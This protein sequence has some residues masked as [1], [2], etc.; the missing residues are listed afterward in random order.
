MEP[1][2]VDT[3]KALNE[4]LNK[5][6]HTASL[7]VRFKEAR[8]NLG[9]S[10]VEVAAHL[11]LAEHV[12]EDIEKDDYSQV[13]SDVYAKGYLRTYAKFVGLPESEILEQYSASGLGKSIVSKQPQLIEKKPPMISRKHQRWAT[14]ALSGILFI[15]F[16]YWWTSG[17]SDNEDTSLLV[18]DA[19]NNVKNEKPTKP[20]KALKKV[21]NTTE[22]Q[23]ITLAKKDNAEKENEMSMSETEETKSANYIE[24]SKTLIVSPEDVLSG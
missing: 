24:P 15:G 20:N 5:V 8:N 3:T 19:K 4:P 13:A 16:I 2:D 22:D 12:I 23:K 7:G 18:L 10:I 9:K 6:Q 21:E 14:Y 11:H 1:N 17:T